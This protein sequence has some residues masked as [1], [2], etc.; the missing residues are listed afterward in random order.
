MLFENTL[1]H[2]L[3]CMIAYLTSLTHSILILLRLCETI[4]MLRHLMCDEI[5]IPWVHSPY[6]CPNPGL[7]T[8]TQIHLWREGTFFII[9][10][11]LCSL[12]WHQSEFDFGRFSF[13]LTW[14]CGINRTWDRPIYEKTSRLFYKQQRN[15]FFGWHMRVSNTIEVNEWVSLPE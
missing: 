8:Q 5:I 14:N 15:F 7:H 6:C 2:S 13:V 11:I 9:R 1:I 10:F 4:W 3:L 12:W